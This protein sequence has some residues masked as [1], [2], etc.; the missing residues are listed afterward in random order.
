MIIRF[1]KILK[2]PIQ[3][4]LRGSETFFKQS[5]RTKRVQQDWSI[6]SPM[7]ICYCKHHTLKGLATG[8]AKQIELYKWWTIR[9]FGNTNTSQ[10]QLF[11]LKR[12]NIGLPTWV[13]RATRAHQYDG[14]VQHY[15]QR[16]A[17][18]QGIQP[19]GSRHSQQ[20]QEAYFYKLADQQCPILRCPRQFGLC[21]I[22]IYIRVFGKPT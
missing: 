18:S 22:I 5:V 21:N 4:Q 20:Q 1:L 13:P 19:I 7:H 8:K 10:A 6:P 9:A 15:P 16:D 2:C 11:P 17:A 12:R 3:M 14:P